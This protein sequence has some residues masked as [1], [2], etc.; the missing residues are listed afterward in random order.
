VVTIVNVFTTNI[1]KINRIPLTKVAAQPQ[2]FLNQFIVFKITHNE[3]QNAYVV[4]LND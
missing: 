2:P 4:A 3:K 1:Q